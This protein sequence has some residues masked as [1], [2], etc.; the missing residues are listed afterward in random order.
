MILGWA[1]FVTVVVYQVMTTACDFRAVS[2]V[3]NII[4]Y[5]AVMQNRDAQSALMAVLELECDLAALS[6]S[7][8]LRQ[9]T[10]PVC[11][12]FFTFATLFDYSPI[13]NPDQSTNKSQTLSGSWCC[14]P[15]N[16]PQSTQ[17]ELSLLLYLAEHATSHPHKASSHVVHHLLIEAIRMESR[18]IET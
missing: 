14:S 5:I 16:S 12:R 6:L 3:L 18:A 7:I 8:R 1:G 13:R 15:N 17:H 9:R 11:Q 4:S 10:N 2:C